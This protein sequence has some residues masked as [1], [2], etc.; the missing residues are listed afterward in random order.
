MMP[1]HVEI[2][3]R[4]PVLTAPKNIPWWLP[5]IGELEHKLVNEVLSS[6]YVNEGE[7]TSDNVIQASNSRR[8]RLLVELS[9]PSD[10]AQ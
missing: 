9:V 3:R 4:G 8:Y 5:R 10:C 6:D 1:Q 2:R 7:F